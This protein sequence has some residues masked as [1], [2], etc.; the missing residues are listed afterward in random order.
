MAEATYP[1]Q[2]PSLDPQQ[3]AA[4]LLTRLDLEDKAGLMFQ[5]MASYGPLGESTAIFGLPSLQSMIEKRRLNHFNLIGSLNSGR[6][7]AEWHNAAQDLAAQVG[8]GLPITFSTDPRHGFTDNPGAAMLAGPFSQWPETLG[9]AAIADAAVVES[10]ADIMRQEYVAVGIRLALHP[11]I[12]LSTEPRWARCNGTFGEDA[13]LSSKLG[14]AYI[15]GLQGEALG[16]E[17][18]AAMTKHFPGGGPQKDGEDPHFEYGKD[19][20]YPGGQFGYHL[21]PF[22]AAIAAGTSQIMPYYGRPVGTEY[23]E[24][25]F[26]FNK[27]VLTDLLRNELGFTGIICTDWGL[28]TDAELFGAPFPARAWG[29]E[30]LSRDERIIK[31]LDAGV[32]QFGG[33]MCSSALVELVRAGRVSE[34]RLDQSVLRLLT[35]KFRLG[36][37]ENRHV[38]AETASI[39]VG[40]EAFRDAGLA[41]Q[42]ASVTLLHNNGQLPLSEGITVY[43]EGVNPTALDGVAQVVDSPEQ[44][45]VI[46][47]RLKAPFD[48]RGTGFESFFHAGSL[49]F[50][51]ETIAH[52]TELA[53]IAPVVVDVYLDRPAIIAPLVAAAAALTVT[54]GTSDFAWVDVLF[55]KDQPQ[56]KL[57]FDIPSSMAAV[58]ASRSDVPFDTENPT[59][60]FGDGLSY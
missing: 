34:A 47:V 41:A 60:R 57:P 42:R 19:Q 23:E 15:R 37:F 17:S 1:Y 40:C 36:L 16:P 43:A 56:G 55:G 53:A 39:I 24:V 51:A 31:A 9:L 18:V 49:E 28:L 5:T 2:D 4:D 14:V 52:L 29:V 44:A 7:M 27:G 59:F 3:R 10:F 46:L 45:A 26:G 35:E 58:V 13:E 8:I 30:Q 38:A 6:E 33:E 22:I 20:V 12:D 32:D 11:Q 21:K 48:E 54:Y 50:P 25:G